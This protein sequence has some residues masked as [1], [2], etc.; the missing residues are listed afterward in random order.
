VGALHRRRHQYR[1]SYPSKPFASLE[2]A[3]AWVERFVR[4]YNEEHRH[5][6]INYV[7]PRERHEGRDIEILAQRKRVYTEAKARHPKR[8]TRTIR[9]CDPVRAVCLNPERAANQA[10]KQSA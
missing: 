2:A 8:W 7:T 5:S 1:P 6:A 10:I 3:R 9:N 4:W